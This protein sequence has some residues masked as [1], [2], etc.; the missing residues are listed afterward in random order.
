MIFGFLTGWLRALLWLILFLAAAALAGWFWLKYEFEAVDLGSTTH[1]VIVKSGDN[2]GV[3]ADSLKAKG[4]IKSRPLF[5]WIG[6]WQKIDRA[7]RPGRYDFSGKLSLFEVLDKFKKGEIVTITFT[8]PE[9]TPIWKVA[10]ILDTEVDIDSIWLLNPANTKSLLAKHSLPTLEG[11]LYPDT[12]TVPWGTGATD[13]IDLLLRTYR[14]K[15]DSLFARYVRESGNLTPDQV[16]ILA[17]IVE[18]EALRDDEEPTIASVYL[19]RYKIGMK[20]DADPT[21]IYGLGGLDRPLTKNDLDRV[22]PYN[23]YRKSGLTPTP[24]NSPGLTAI[25]AVMRPEK[26]EYLF[27]VADGTGRHRFSRTNE[28]HNRARAEI[29]RKQRQGK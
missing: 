6:K 24:I 3:I 15:T 1:T 4:V 9:G 19:N 5:V 8:I 18:A 28:E 26:T 20:L 29:K 2:Y 13:V 10:S 25:Q 16:M 17:S 11:Y 21:V 7:I 14:E 23:T 22:T 12:Y 27:F